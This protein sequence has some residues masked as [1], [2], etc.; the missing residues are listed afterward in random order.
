MATLKHTCKKC[1][2][3]NK[4]T[5]SWVDPKQYTVPD[6]AS[7]KYG[8]WCKN[9]GINTGVEYRCIPPDRVTVIDEFN[10]ALNY[11]KQRLDPSKDFDLNEWSEVVV[12]EA[13][14]EDSIEV[15]EV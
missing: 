3:V 6:K 11:T 13:I 9:C 8:Y 14:T 15:E 2:F 10:P 5:V 1:K 4:K 12:P 7:V